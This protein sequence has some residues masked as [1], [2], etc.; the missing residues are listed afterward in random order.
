MTDQADT[1]AAQLAPYRETPGIVAALLISR[2]GFVVAADADAAFATD[3]VAAQVAG[4]IDVGARLAAELA[5]PEARYISV[6]FD[7]LNLV[8]APFGGELM[9]VLVGLPSALTC[10]YRLTKP[11]A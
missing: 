7:E 1:L 3:A 8:L 9:L 10:E 5:Q 2:D 11:G 4:V 6:D